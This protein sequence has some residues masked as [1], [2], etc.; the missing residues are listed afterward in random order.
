MAQYRAEIVTPKN[1]LSRLGHK[2]N[3]L[4]ISLNGWNSGVKVTVDFEDNEDVFRIYK[5]DGSNG[6]TTTLL[7]TI[8]S[9]EAKIKDLLNCSYEET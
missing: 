5:T 4:S 3:G 2:P 7:A 9:K 1:I 8:N 6:Y